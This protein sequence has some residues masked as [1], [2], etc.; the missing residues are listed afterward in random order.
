MAK[1]EGRDQLLTGGC[2]R[3]ASCHLGNFLYRAMG[4][5]VFVDFLW[6]TECKLDT[7]ARI[8]LKLEAMGLIC[9]RM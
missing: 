4:T 8:C 5:Q 9:C 3:L 6:K 7:K 1:E 2:H